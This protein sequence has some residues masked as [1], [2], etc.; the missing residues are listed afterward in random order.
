MTRSLLYSLITFLVFLLVVEVLLSSTHLFGARR[1]WTRPDPLIGWR[2][3]PNARFW[4]DQ[5]NDHPI[6]GRINN[7]GWRDR[8]RQVQK[9]PDTVRVAVLGDSYVEA[10]QVELDSTF[11]ARAERR[12]NQAVE[13]PVE[14][15][16][17]GRS[18]MTQTEEMLVLHS[19]VLRHDPDVVVLVFLPSNDIE[20]VSSE[21]TYDIMRPFY[22]DSGDGELIL[23]T[24]FADG[25]AFAVK[26]LI[27]PLKQR[28]ALLSLITERYN[29]I[30]QA[31]RR[32]ELSEEQPAVGRITGVQSLCT[33]TPD[34]RYAENYRLNKRLIRD[35]AQI[36]AR[37]GR[38]FVL[39]CTDWM[40]RADIIGRKQSIDATFDPDFFDRDLAALADSVGAEYVGLQ[41]IFAQQYAEQGRP[42]HWVHW[43]YEGH[44][45]V[46]DALVRK[47]LP[48]MEIE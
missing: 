5:E 17:F 18:G 41:D 40:Y 15:L 35:M 20:D 1:A 48:M 39:V 13:R 4:F 36:C 7:H 22:R 38:R 32:S 2:L 6:S 11:T 19:D 29:L 33:Q 12:L 9:L 47:L 46:A 21:T 23:D 26:R 14:V 37:D 45:I 16:N 30:R 25:R 42:L 27:N 28:S 24:S 43:N 34:A 3:E 8:D 31:R 44:R 10:L